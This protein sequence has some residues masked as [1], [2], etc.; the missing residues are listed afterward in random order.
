MHILLMTTARLLNWTNQR[1]WHSCYES[2]FFWSRKIDWTILPILTPKY[3]LLNWFVKSTISWWDYL[4]LWFFFNSFM[5]L[6]LFA[7][8]WRIPFYSKAK[9]MFF[10]Y[11]WYPKTKVL[12][13]SLAQD[14]YICFHCR[15]LHTSM[16]L[17]LS[18]I[19]HSMKMT[20]MVI[21]LSWELEP[22]IWLLFIS[23]NLHPWDRILSLMFWNM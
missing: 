22:Q 20:L 1:I 7:L 19:F 23:R 6:S 17:S 21:C 3:E 8:M 15:Q 2:K 5:T 10:I 16:G 11:L 4:R 13:S 12:N 18:R 9:L 14:W